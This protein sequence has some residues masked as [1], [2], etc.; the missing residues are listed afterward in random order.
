MSN[1]KTITYYNKATGR[2]EEIEG[3]L[4]DYYESTPGH[5][6]DTL[7]IDGVFSA[8]STNCTTYTLAGTD[9]VVVAQSAE[10][11]VW[12]TYQ[13][14]ILTSLNL[15]SDYFRI[16]AAAWNGGQY[17]Q[18]GYVMRNAQFTGDI[19]VASYTAVY[20]GIGESLGYKTKTFYR[21]D[22]DAVDADEEDI[23]NVIKSK[24]LSDMSL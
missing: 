6:S 15:S 21:A 13:T 19:Y 23:T 24:Q 8:P 9:N 5:W 4:K 3:I 2:D 18:D 7:V 10:T 11:P 1:T 16:N 14:D 20:E 17:S 22:A 12:E